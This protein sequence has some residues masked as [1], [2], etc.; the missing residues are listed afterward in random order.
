[1]KEHNPEINKQ[2][3]EYI[4]K[5]GERCEEGELKI[6]TVN[7]KED[8]L[9]FISFLK[10]S[11][12]MPPN[13][14]KKQE[15]F[16]YKDAIKENHRFNPF[17]SLFLRVLV[18]IT[19]NRVRDRENF[20]FIRTKT[21]GMVRQIFR[22]IDKELLQ[23]SKIDSAGDSQYL[24]YEEI[25]NLELSDSYKEIIS[26][27]KTEYDSYRTVDHAIRYHES[28]GQFIP[29]D[30]E[31]S[32]CDGLK[33]SG[34]C[35]GIVEGNALFVDSSSIHDL[36]VEGKILVAQFF[37]PGWIGLFARSGGLI[38]ERGSLLS[39]TAILCRELGIPSIIGAKGVTSNLKNGERIRMN[40]ATGIIEKLSVNEEI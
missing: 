18:K 38:S 16:D 22:M 28:D 15:L 20:R 11:L 23:T 14:N 4:S 10:S 17:K 30:L 7:Y 29:V 12:M 25:M 24:F 26:K 19:V 35:S 31:N 32:S 37:E 39:H 3:G 40:G 21:F 8:P 5:Y 27:R 9:K 33:G 2:I 34:C 6:E 13:Q 1:L 36:D